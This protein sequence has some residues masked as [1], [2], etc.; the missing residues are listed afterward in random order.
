MPRTVLIADESI[1]IRSVAESLL[2]GESFSVHSAADGQMA[3]EIARAEH[4]ELALIGEKLSGLSGAEVCTSLKNDPE[5]RNIPIILMRADRPGAAPEHADAVLTKPFSPQ[6]L[7]DAVHR[8]LAVDE[9]REG[10]TP[11]NLNDVT[12]PGLEE[13]LIDSALG[14]DDVGPSPAEEREIVSGRSNVH[15]NGENEPATPFGL[16][17]DVL[18]DSGHEE[19]DE[20]RMSKAL[21]ESFGLLAAERSKPAPE[22]VAD[23][24]RLELEAT[25]RRDSSDLDL[26]SALDAAFGDSPRGRARLA[27][28]AQQE[29]G[30]L[31]EI[32]LGDQSSPELT[33]A[34]LPP[35]SAA[36]GSGIDLGGGDEIQEDRPHDYDW[37]INEMQQDGGPRSD[38][39]APIEPPRIEPLVPKGS[40][41]TAHVS[42]PAPKPETPAPAQSSR[43]YDDF[44]SEFR[45][46]IARIEGMA[47]PTDSSLPPGP[48]NQTKSQTGK[49][50][51]E[52]TG[53]RPLPPTPPSPPATVEAA[54]QAWGDELIDTVTAQVARELAA[55]ID[56]KV[57]YSLIEQKLKEAQKRRS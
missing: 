3:L 46:E 40:A 53:E 16:V 25:N 11:V 6:S 8:F 44:I 31:Q 34:K 54:V 15:L 37:F 9:Q 22:A 33:G 47:G 21:D 57:I 51:F 17:D 30:S 43:A 48:A 56:S 28:P 19:S 36:P 55:K 52:Q 29:P 42:K 38:R 45:A 32:S 24:D 50:A 18:R 4:P 14:L 12:P 35:S 23:S 39:P 13:E 26:D 41:P 7:L 5:L 49:I 27:P 1:T 20:E 10:T 2:R